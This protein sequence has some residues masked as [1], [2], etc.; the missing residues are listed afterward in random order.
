MPQIVQMPLARRAAELR[1]ETFN[2]SDYT[3]DMCW[4]TGSTGRRMSWVD[5][6]YDEELVV[7]PNAVRLDRLN[8]GATQA[9]P[10]QYRQLVDKYYRALASKPKDQR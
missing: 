5:G 2:E 10:E 4:T 8:A 6:P 1:A 3:M 9:V 7:A